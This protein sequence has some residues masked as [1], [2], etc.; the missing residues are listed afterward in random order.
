MYRA[1]PQE[2][3]GVSRS[4]LDVLAAAK[5]DKVASDFLIAALKGKSAVDSTATD[6]QF[7]LPDLVSSEAKEQ[8]SSQQEQELL[9]P[10]LRPVSKPQKYFHT[11]FSKEQIKLGAALQRE[12]QKK[13]AEDALQQ[14]GEIELTQEEIDE[15]MQ[16]DQAKQDR[17]QRYASQM[18]E[19]EEQQ[20]DD[21]DKPDEQQKEDETGKLRDLTVEQMASNKPREPKPKNPHGGKKRTEA[22]QEQLEE[23]EE[24]YE[25]RTEESTRKRKA[26]GCINPQEAAKFQ[27]FIK[28]RM[29]ELVGEMKAGKDL[30]NPVHRF[31]RALKLQYDKVHLFENNGAANTKDIVDMIPNTKRI[32]WRKALEGKEIVD[33]DEYN[34]IINCCME[35]HL[36][37]EGNLHLKLDEMVF[38]QE[39]D[40]V[41]QRIMQKCASLFGNVEKAHQVNLEVARDL[42]DLANMIK[43]PEVFSKITQAA[44][45]PLVT[46]YTPRIDMFIKQCQVTIDAKQE[47]LS[48]PKSI[49]E[50]MEMS[51]LPQ[52]NIAWGDKNNKE[53]AAT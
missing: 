45:Q 10:L 17:V 19:K 33:A 35:S 1:N 27:N 34:L 48:K 9:K 20:E 36:F 29:E 43:E 52:Y 4:L 30:I 16:K 37:Q 25:E 28:D 31:I 41:K 50:L 46:C 53:K 49:D 32:A 24:E 44:M 47:K 42:K 7:K 38:G 22:V 21:S 8:M 11:H 15:R 6:D 14:G 2:Q 13:M 40:E 3:G 18:K 51:N 5:E 23:E 26:I 39:T 12:Q